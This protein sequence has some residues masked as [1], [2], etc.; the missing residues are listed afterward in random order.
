M[1][2]RRQQR[3]S[4]RA[5]PTPGLR[6]RA[7]AL[8]ACLV[9]AATASCGPSD[10]DLQDVDNA[11]APAGDLQDVDYAPLPGGDWE[12]S[13]PGAEGLDPD[14]V[15]ELFDDAGD[16]DTLY[17]LLVVKNGHLV[18]E[19]YFNE[20]SVEQKARLQSVTKSYMSA[21]VGIALDRG[22]LASVDQKMLEFYPEVAGQVTDP[23][24]AEITLR[25]MLQMRAGF[26]SEESHQDLWDGL[27]S[28]RYVPRIEGFPLE[29][30]S[31]T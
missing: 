18:A 30:T 16:L 27:L 24:K 6:A 12:V 15:A 14:L 23:R 26:P 8:L 3:G 21:L 19:Q 5:L 11:P 17:S 28:G 4:S 13:T 2:R 7:M 1:N 20:G 31:T 25:E 29:A 9:L 10:G 22:C